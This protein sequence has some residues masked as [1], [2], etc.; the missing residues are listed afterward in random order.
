MIRHN[1][2][3]IAGRLM[4]FTAALAQSIEKQQGGPDLWQRV[5]IDQAWETL[6]ETGW[7]EMAREAVG[8]Q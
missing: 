8:D 1:Y 7:T 6:D 4:F 2:P 5:L 3:V